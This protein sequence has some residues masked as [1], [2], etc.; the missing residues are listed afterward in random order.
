MKNILI[1]TTALVA[2]AGMAAAEINFSGGA[3]FGVVY[4]EN[5]TV[6][7]QE[8]KVHNRFTINIDGTAETDSGVE[9]FG[10][11]RIRGGNE[12]NGNLIGGGALGASG[13]S[14]PRVGARIGGLTIAV[15]NI[16]GAIDSLAGVYSGSIGLTGLSYSNVVNNNQSSGAFGY[17]SFSS[18]G[19]GSNGVEVIYSGNGF[20]AHLSDSSSTDRTALGL[21]YAF[22]DWTV[23]LGVQ[24]SGTLG[25]DFTSIGVDGSI[26]TVTVGAAY[27]D[28]EGDF[29]TFRIN[30]GFEIGAATNVTVYVADNSGVGRETAYGVGFTHSL[31]GA[32]LAGGIEND[33]TGL[34]RADFGVRFN[35]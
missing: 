11:V 33:R 24:E 19:A 6:G 30:A 14:A 7:A 34:T 17:D 26:G 32:T 9:F 8:S 5:N 18:G 10:R 21:S 20:N 4:D 13:V 2:T 12:G 16:N 3:R 1:A 35:F 29:D 22:G 27:A 15:G 28:N 31:G 25:E 23:A